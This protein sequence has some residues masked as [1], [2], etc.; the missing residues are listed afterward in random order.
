[1][2]DFLDEF[3]IPILAGLT[4]LILVIGISLGCYAIWG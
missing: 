2:R 3:G 4:Y 1:V